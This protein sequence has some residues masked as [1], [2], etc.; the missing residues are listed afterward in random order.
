MFAW[1][2]N[3]YGQTGGGGSAISNMDVVYSPR[4]VNFEAHFRPRIEAHLSPKCIYHYRPSIVK[5]D[6]GGSHSAFVDDI[7]RLFLCGN[8]KAGQLGI[9]SYVNQ[10]APCHIEDIQEGVTQVSCG[11]NQTVAVTTKGKVWVM[12]SNQ[13]GQLGIGEKYDN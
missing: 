9:G 8:N 6:C 3:S 4:L 13:N 1:G 11:T 12:G 10:A 5:I 2:D 7:G